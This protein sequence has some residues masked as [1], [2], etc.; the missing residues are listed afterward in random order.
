[1]V[2]GLAAL[3]AGS[4]SLGASGKG[5]VASRYVVGVCVLVGFGAALLVPGDTHGPMGVPVGTLVVAL[6][7]GLIPLVVLPVI[8]ALSS[9][10]DRKAVVPPVPRSDAQR[11]TP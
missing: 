9:G 6:C 7:V 1:M 11:R 3:F 10:D 5:A 8:F 4:V 2:C